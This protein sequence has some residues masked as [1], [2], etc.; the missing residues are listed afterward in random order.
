MYLLNKCKPLLGM[1]ADNQTRVIKIRQLHLLL[2]FYLQYTIII[3]SKTEVINEEA[4]RWLEHTFPKFVSV[5][6]N[7]PDRDADPTD[8]SY[9]LLELMVKWALELATHQKLSIAFPWNR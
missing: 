9:K 8:N 2:V 6:R 4:I 1:I 7:G 5:M 3:S